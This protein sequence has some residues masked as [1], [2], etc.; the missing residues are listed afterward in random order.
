MLIVQA[1][2]IMGLACDGIVNVFFE[3]IYSLYVKVSVLHVK[4][5][6]VKSATCNVGLDLQTNI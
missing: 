6:T 4:G 2:L 3:S 5:S 1:V